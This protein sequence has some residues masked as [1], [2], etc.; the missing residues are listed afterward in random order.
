MSVSYYSCGQHLACPK[1]SALARRTDPF[2]RPPRCMMLGSVRS[3]W[4]TPGVMVSGTS[5][6]G[7]WPSRS[8]NGEVLTFYSSVAGSG[9]LT[10]STGCVTGIVDPSSGCRGLSRGCVSSLCVGSAD[11]FPPGYLLGPLLRRSLVRLLVP[12]VEWFYFP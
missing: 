5:S 10:S 8:V 11:W 3:S 12:H 9:V 2:T 6:R 7:G 4:F 1:Y